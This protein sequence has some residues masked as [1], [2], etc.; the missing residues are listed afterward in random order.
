MKYFVFFMSISLFMLGCG[1]GKESD[2]NLPKENA[3]GKVKKEAIKTKSI[4][5]AGLTW[6]SDIDATFMSA[7]KENKDVIVM[8]GEPDCRYCTKMKK[9]TLSNPKVAALLKKY[10]LVYIR[11]SDEKSIKF[12]PNFDGN[13]HGNIP[14]FFFMKADRTLE[15]TIVGY[16]KV[17]TFMDMLQLLEE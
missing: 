16:Y 12:L 3:E 7:Q 9:R 13:A 8:V 10:A 2:M 1:D 14:S 5:I 4:Q 11:R 6:H 17:D 15:E